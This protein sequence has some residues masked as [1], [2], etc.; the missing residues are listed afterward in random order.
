MIAC[1]NNIY[2]YTHILL[3]CDNIHCNTSN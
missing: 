1:V 3:Q 2:I